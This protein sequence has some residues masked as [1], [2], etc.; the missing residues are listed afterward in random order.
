MRSKFFADPQ[1]PSDGFFN[2]EGSEFFPGASP[3]AGNDPGRASR[4]TG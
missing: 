1:D 3:P 2:T 4:W